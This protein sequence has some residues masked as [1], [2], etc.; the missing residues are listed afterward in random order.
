MLKTTATMFLAAAA[1]SLSACATTGS[2]SLATK[3][4]YHPFDAKQGAPA[5]TTVASSPAPKLLHD[6][7]EMK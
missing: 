1:L 4:H 3:P 5:S 2:S 6:H 7:R